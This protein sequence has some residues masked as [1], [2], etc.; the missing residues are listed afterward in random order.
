MKYASFIYS[1]T[2]IFITEELGEGIQKCMEN[3]TMHW[4]KT[5]LLI[6]N[7]AI[8]GGDFVLDKLLAQNLPVVSPLLQTNHYQARYDVK[9]DVGWN[10][11]KEGTVYFP[12]PFTTIDTTIGQE[13]YLVINKYYYFCQYL[14]VKFFCRE[15]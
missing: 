15:E 3:F 2:N 6:R 13:R 8:L 14:L 11:K 4:T 1:A 10:K 7:T 9:C 5:M 12:T